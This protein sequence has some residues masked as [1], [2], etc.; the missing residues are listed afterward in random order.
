[1]GEGKEQLTIQSLTRLPNMLRQQACLTASETRSLLLIE[2]ET[3]D[4][5]M[6]VNCTEIY[7]DRC[8]RPDRTGLRMMM[9]KGSTPDCGASRAYMLQARSSI[10]FRVI[11]TDCVLGAASA[12]LKHRL[13][14]TSP[15]SAHTDETYFSSSLPGTPPPPCDTSILI[16]DESQTGTSFLCSFVAVCSFS[17]SS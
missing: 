15:A 11:T 17:H 12:A 5:N 10:S 1:M 8:C 9:S 2:D 14:S 13:P 3:A 7:L 6:S 4:R 16:L